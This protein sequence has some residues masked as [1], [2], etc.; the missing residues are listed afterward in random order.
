LTERCRRS[1]HVFRNIVGQSN[2]AADALIRQDRID[3]LVDL[4]MH[5]SDNRLLLFARRPAP[6]QITYLAYCGTTGL[7]AIDY[8]ITDPHLDPP[9]EATPYYS[10]KSLWLPETYWCYEAPD[11]GEISSLPAEKAGCVTF[12]C[13]NN[14]CKVSGAAL[15]IWAKLLAATP[16]ARLLL[17][18]PEGQA[19]QRVREALIAHG[20]DANRLE[21][22]GRTSF[23]EY[24]A[25]YH[26]V[27]IALDP[28]PYGGGTTTC[29]A[30]WMGVPVVTLRGKLA[31][32]R[33]GASILSNVG[34]PELIAGSEERY[35]EIA[36]GLANDLPRL[37]E[38]RATLRQRMRQSPLMN[39]A[40]FA[41]AM[42]SLYE[43]CA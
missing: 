42:E 14:F 22:V 19:R 3:I 29:D 40:R 12:G 20:L 31:V 34:L 18:A 30:M 24:A 16:H 27:D 13:F 37:A 7:D 10:E 25:Y 5:M 11:C 15:E 26:R 39:A 4:T 41:R 6:V 32:G 1:A 35:V 36:A 38:L 8:R 33:G 23:P 43:K 21:F 2:A 28:F 17:H 9:G